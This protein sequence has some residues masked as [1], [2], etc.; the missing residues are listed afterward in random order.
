MGTRRPKKA[1]RPLRGGV[2]DSLGGQSAFADLLRQKLA[3][4][5]T[6]PT[7]NNR[8]VETFQTVSEDLTQGMQANVKDNE[9]RV[10][11]RQMADSMVRLMDEINRPDVSP[12]DARDMAGAVEAYRTAFQRLGHEERQALV[13]FAN[14]LMADPNR[15]STQLL[16][17]QG[18]PRGDE[19]YRFYGNQPAMPAA[20]E[21]APPSL[22]DG[23]RRARAQ[24]MDLRGD[25][26]DYESRSDGSTLPFDQTVRGQSNEAILRSLI[27][28]YGLDPSIVEGA[29]VGDAAMP[30]PVPAPGVFLDRSEY[31]AAERL[32]SYTGKKYAGGARYASSLDKR[33]I[34][35]EKGG[36]WGQIDAIRE[37]QEKGELPQGEPILG[38]LRDEPLSLSIL[39][40]DRADKAA[41]RQ[42][43]PMNERVLE[44]LWRH[45]FGEIVSAGGASDLDTLTSLDGVRKGSS[46]GFPLDWVAPWASGTT[47]QIGPDGSVVRAPFT[48]EQV[49]DTIL[50]QS[51]FLAEQPYL[52]SAARER[53]LPQ[54]AEAME[55]ARMEKGGTPG[56]EFNRSALGLKLL[57][58]DAKNIK[59]VLD[60]TQREKVKGGMRKAGPK[61]NDLGF[62]DQLIIPRM[63][64][65]TMPN[66][67][68]AALLG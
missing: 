32:S 37:K 2:G 53:L 44:T 56:K 38:G 31:P 48:P 30:T 15:P 65:E 49:T 57:G 51:G 8:A 4:D 66:R 17:N 68:L 28:D 10:E 13:G 45:S 34:G 3:E 39:D 6:V 23:L 58:P 42:M 22:I 19:M 33:K 16:A 47:E 59:P 25:Q 46:K 54:I 41:A 7:E 9:K 20:P 1:K 62:S 27:S 52:R 12:D 21:G 18:S 29:S 61:K 50:S 60:A 24:Q 64:G 63:A 55:T 11:L 35:R 43:T 26:G 40:Q 67:L 5:E 14:E 36:L